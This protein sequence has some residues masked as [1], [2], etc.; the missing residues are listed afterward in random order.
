LSSIEEER[1]RWELVEQRGS[2]RD[3]VGG[4]VEVDR[5]EVQEGRVV[6]K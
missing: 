5:K 2:R 6:S 1:S 3:V 4:G